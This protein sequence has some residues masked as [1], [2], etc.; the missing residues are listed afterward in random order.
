MPPL[1]TS[2]IINK[3]IYAKSYL[4][5]F[6]VLMSATMETMEIIKETAKDCS[7]IIFVAELDKVWTKIL[8]KI[9][10][11]HSVIQII[12]SLYK[13]LCIHLFI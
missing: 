2:T 9:M 12:T 4:R 5:G 1:K 7:K 6:L 3:L 13:N 8:R 10:K 11:P